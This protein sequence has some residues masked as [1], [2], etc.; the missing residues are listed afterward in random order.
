M[1]FLPGGNIDFVGR[2]DGQVKIRGFRIEL[3]EVERIIREFDGIKDATV[4]AFDEP[5][6]GKFVAA[7]V[8]SDEKIDIK[9]LNEFILENKPP[10][11]VPAVT[12]QIDKIPL[13]QNQK[14]NK[15]ALPIPQKQVEDIIAPE[16]EI[17][18]RIFDCISEVIGTDSFG[19]T[20]DIFYAGLTSIGA[21]KLNVL[22]SK[23]FDVAIKINDLKENNTV[24][25]LEKF[26]SNSQTAE[27]YDILSD[28][29]ITQTQN[30]IFVECAANPGTTIYNI[31][32]L[33]KLSKNIDI[34]RLKAA[35]ESTINAH[36]YIKT[37]LFINEKGDIRALRN[38]KIG[39]ASC[40]ERV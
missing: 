27:K 30:G 2:N 39:R 6:G 40:R 33:L 38:D 4:A 1:R 37:K 31:P 26:L 36:P 16:N 11:M 12:M 28:Y 3:S 20:T 7:Y 22:L 14:V 19:I 32:Y 24:K 5:G 17:Q 9:K 34:N 23:A 18:Q 25:K 13:N 21:I 29:P 10:Y 35:V 8:V 15:R